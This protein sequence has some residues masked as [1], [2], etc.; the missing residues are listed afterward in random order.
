MVSTS[1]RCVKRR[2]QLGVE[3]P[4]CEVSTGIGPENGSVLADDD[5]RRQGD[6]A[7]FIPDAIPFDYVVTFRVTD[8]GVGQQQFLDHGL[9]LLRR[10]YGDADD[11]SSAP[12]DLVVL[13]GKAHGLPIAVRSPIAPIE[14]QQLRTPGEGVS[15]TPC[16]TILVDGGEVWRLDAD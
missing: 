3:R 7:S 15:E 5:H 8:D 14:E 9:V 6:P 1:S 4:I 13:P 2:E 10:V 12:G 16:A 11:L